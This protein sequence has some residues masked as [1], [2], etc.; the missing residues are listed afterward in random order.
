MYKDSRIKCG[1]DKNRAYNDNQQKITAALKFLEQP[2]SANFEHD[3]FCR[4]DE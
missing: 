1:N 4:S 3:G 2:F